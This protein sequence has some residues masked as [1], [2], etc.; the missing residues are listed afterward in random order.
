MSTQI[1]NLD[2]RWLPNA[3]TE[4]YI[5]PGLAHSSLISTLNFFNAG[6]KVMFD[7]NKCRV[8]YQGKRV[9]TGGRDP[10]TELWRLPINS[11]AVYNAR[12]TL[13]HVDL[14]IPTE[15]MFIGSQAIH[16]ANNVH[17]I[18]YKQH[19]LKY[20]HQS[21]FSPPIDTFINH[22]SNNSLEGFRYCLFGVN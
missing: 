15:P 17:I 3:M 13:S 6:C 21:M 10:M 8:Y 2:I 12:P 14:H 11:S 5:V 9:I 16:H 1:C 19:Q 7:Q 20:I 18:P 22:I 4:A